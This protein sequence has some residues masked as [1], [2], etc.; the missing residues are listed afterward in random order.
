MDEN[1]FN[2]FFCWVATGVSDSKRFA[3]SCSMLW[4]RRLRL[5][6]SS[7]M[8]DGGLEEEAEELA[9]LLVLE[10]VVLGVW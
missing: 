9:W 3:C 2:R 1:R 8:G 7:T 6:V 10:P 5:L 4:R